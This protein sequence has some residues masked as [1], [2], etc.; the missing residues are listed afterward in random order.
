MSGVVAKKLAQV[1]LGTVVQVDVSPGLEASQNLAAMKG[2]QANLKSGADV[3][4][5]LSKQLPNVF[6]KQGNIFRMSNAAL[7]VVA[8]ILLEMVA[9]VAISVAA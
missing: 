7:A 9:K 6:G 3:P 4:V 1:V 2:A 5:E 8:R